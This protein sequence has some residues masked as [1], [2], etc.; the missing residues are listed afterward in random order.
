MSKIKI[1]VILLILPPNVILR[2]SIT[3]LLL[4][5]RQQRDLSPEDHSY[6]KWSDLS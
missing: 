3:P 1:L 6:P 5:L 4:R 2:L